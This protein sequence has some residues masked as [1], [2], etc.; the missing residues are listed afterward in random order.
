MSFTPKEI[1]TSNKIL[2][3]HYCQLVV[4]QIRLKILLETISNVNM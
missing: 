1:K 4:R 3:L 2:S